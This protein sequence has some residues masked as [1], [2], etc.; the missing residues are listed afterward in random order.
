MPGEEPVEV[1]PDELALV[2]AGFRTTVA[3]AKAVLDEYGYTVEFFADIYASFRDELDARVREAIGD[4]IAQNSSEPLTDQATEAAV[5]AHMAR[6][7]GGPLDDL[8][9]FT[10]FLRRAIETDLRIEPLLA[11]VTLGQSGQ[12]VSAR[13]YLRIRRESLT[14]FDSLQM[15]ADRVPADV[16]RALALFDEG[17]VYLYPEVISLL[18]TRLVL[19]AMDDDA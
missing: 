15:L 9:A 2:E 14:D 13:D 3:E 10:A 18:Y 11:D 1:D 7:R 6:S 16:M 5:E 8:R 17:Y 12:T 19:D 4:D